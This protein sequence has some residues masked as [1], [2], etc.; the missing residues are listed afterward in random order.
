MLVAMDLNWVA[1]KFQDSK[2]ASF[3]NAHF[4][5]Y[6][7]SFPIL[8]QQVVDLWFSQPLMCPLQIKITNWKSGT[9][10]RPPCQPNYCT[11]SG[12]TSHLSLLYHPSLS[13]IYAC[14][15]LGLLHAQAASLLQSCPTNIDSRKPSESWSSYHQPDLATSFCCWL[16]ATLPSP[17]MYCSSSTYIL[18]WVTFHLLLNFESIKLDNATW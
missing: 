5:A 13:L 15:V 7:S 18:L 1:S 12:I 11:C 4:S 9:E 14:R 17:H 3:F 2:Y 10:H 8:S 16:P 6:W